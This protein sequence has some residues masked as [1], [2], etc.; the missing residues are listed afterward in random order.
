MTQ[1]QHDYKFVKA[2]EDDWSWFAT[3]RLRNIVAQHMADLKTDA[4]IELIRRAHRQGFNAGACMVQSG[5]KNA[6]G[7]R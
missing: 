7:V 3:D 4:I 6:L 2:E 5:V 1:P